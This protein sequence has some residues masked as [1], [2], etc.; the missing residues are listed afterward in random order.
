MIIFPDFISSKPFG[1]DFFNR[2]PL[3]ESLIRL[4]K[5]NEKSLVISV[6]GAWGEGKTYFIDNWLKSL[7]EDKSIIRIKFNAYE[8]DFT[9]EVFISIASN[10]EL[11]I[12]EHYGPDWYDKNEEDRLKEQRNILGKDLALLGG[13]SLV[14]LTLGIDINGFFKKRIETKER[15]NKNVNKALVDEKFDSFLKLKK[16]IS[17]YKL[18]LT[19]ALEFQGQSNKIL[20]VIDELDRCRPEFALRVIE[21]IKHLFNAKNVHFVLTVNKSQ[22]LSCIKHAYGVD[23]RDARIYWQKFLD[24]ETV[25]PSLANKSINTDFENSFKLFV[26]NRIKVHEI[27]HD[28][29]DPD[30]VAWLLDFVTGSEKIKMVPRSIERVF[31]FFTT[32]AV[33]NDHDFMVKHWRL[34]FF[35]ILLR[36]EAPMYYNRL[37]KDKGVLKASHYGSTSSVSIS[38]RNQSGQSFP[39]IIPKLAQRY[40]SNEDYLE[41][42]IEGNTTFNNFEEVINKVEMYEFSSGSD[43][44]MKEMNYKF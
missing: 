19:E 6:N 25:L 18:R 31:Q 23:E 32:I 44:K 41:D 33:S 36:L 37:R 20:F 22:L 38:L 13:S 39:G 26:L 35:L 24:I 14:N 2:E 10:I 9:D 7:E 4:I 34:I 21:K 16:T 15:F 30:K 8:N 40:L 5:S 29:I 11:A 17:D 12:A 43:K 28:I 3:S 27:P 1:D 42:S